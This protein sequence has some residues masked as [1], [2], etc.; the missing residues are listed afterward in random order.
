MSDGIRPA[1]QRFSPASSHRHAGRV[2]VAAAALFLTIAT[3]LHAGGVKLASYFADHVVLQRDKW[4]VPT[5]E[6]AREFS[7]VAY[8]F[9]TELLSG[10]GSVN[11]P[12]GV[13]DDSFGGTTCEAW[14]PNGA[15]ARF[16][17]GDLRDSMFGIK[18]G[19]I[20]NAMIAPLGRTPVKGVVWYQGESN[21]GHPQTYPKLL[22]SLIAEWRKQ[23][24][25]ADLPFLVVQLPDYAPA[26]DGLHWQWI[27][28][29]QA[30]TVA[31]TPHAALAVGIN[32]TDGF[33]LH[34][35]QK[36]EIGRRLA[37]LALHDVY[38]QDVAA[39]GP[40]FKSAKPVGP[41][42]RVEF[43]TAG[44]GL[45]A[46]T[47]GAI[48][49][50]AVAG[51]DGVYRFADATID[52]DNIM[53]QS[54]LV[55]SPKTVRYAWAGIPESTL[56]NKSGLPA[57]PFRTDTLDPPDVEIQKEPVVR[58]VSTTA[59]ELT[60]SGDGQ[61]TSLGV[62]GKQF[63]SNALGAAGGTS[64]PVLFGARSLSTIE[65]IGPDV[66]SCSDGQVTL[67]L[68]C[69]PQDMSWTLTNRG[70]DPVSFRIA[71]SLQVAATDTRI[72][73]V[74]LKRGNAVLLVSGI[75]SVSKSDDGK[76]LEAVVKAGAEKRLTL[77]VVKP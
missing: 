50:F 14:L 20:Y 55:P 9:A 40:V 32:T 61:I 48:R 25:D 49:G 18:P 38:Q 10:P 33:N 24:D 64:I 67:L 45:A 13:I 4:R 74:E 65:E 46:R 70:K 19:M 8:Y 66:I 62:H 73:P 29:A 23:F 22:S 68:E 26:S 76:V 57:A 58:H 12:I 72:E 54:E 43:D 59:Y 36:H 11:V 34:P 60:V 27:R 21:A 71:L 30:T 75:D 39:H 1:L 44:D 3:P 6:T 47:P 31:A 52:G 28:E 63:L 53:L 17:A 69:R 2:A 77:T 35:K 7:A 5:P 56:A 37:L 51:D 15:L 42:L 41:S 16:D